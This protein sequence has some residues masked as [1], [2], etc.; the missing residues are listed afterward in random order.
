MKKEKKLDWQIQIYAP[1]RMTNVSLNE[2]ISRVQ[3]N[4]RTRPDFIIFGW[5]ERQRRQRLTWQTNSRNTFIPS[6]RQRHVRNSKRRL[7][8][9]SFP[10]YRFPVSR[11]NRITHSKISQKMH[12]QMLHI[13]NGFRV[14]IKSFWAFWHC[15]FRFEQHIRNA[16]N[17]YYLY[18]NF[19]Q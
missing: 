3:T 11:C 19:F 14:S 15:L 17:Y 13:P 7:G 5:M 8:S 4:H 2:A 1:S 12:R 16:A 9:N 18:V 6:V 10:F